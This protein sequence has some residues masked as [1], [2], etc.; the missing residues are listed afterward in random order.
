M[1]IDVIIKRPHE[2][3]KEVT[4]PNALRALQEIV[5]GPIEQYTVR[6]DLAIVCNEEGRIRGLTRNCSVYGSWFYGTII[7]VGVDGESFSDC[8]ITLEEFE[9]DYT[10]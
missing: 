6:A 5:G 1:M 10:D 7:V 3:P 4:I 9:H 2:S 8:P